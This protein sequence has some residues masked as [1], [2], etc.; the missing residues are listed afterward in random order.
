MLATI[1]SRLFINDHVQYQNA[2]LTE[3]NA[4]LG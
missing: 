2:A 3:E 1:Y 4:D